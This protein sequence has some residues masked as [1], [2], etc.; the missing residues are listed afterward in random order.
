MPQW[1]KPGL[2]NKG[3][4]AVVIKTV[5]MAMPIKPIAT[6]RIICALDF[7]NQ[8][9]DI[10]MESRTDLAV[11]IPAKLL[12][13]MAPEQWQIRFEHQINGPDVVAQVRK[14]INCPLII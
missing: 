7:P 14:D 9:P 12:E 10:V 5:E 13:C 2:F 8:V 11:E 1:R 4:S 6:V 3:R